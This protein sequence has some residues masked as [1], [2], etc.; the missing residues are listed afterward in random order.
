LDIFQEAASL[1]QKSDTSPNHRQPRMEKNDPPTSS[2]IYQCMDFDEGLL[3]YSETEPV[4]TGDHPLSVQAKLRFNAGQARRKLDDFVGAASYYKKALRI[5]MASD[6]TEATPVSTFTA[7]RVVIPILHNIGQLSYKKGNLKKS[8]VAYKLAL[9]HCRQHHGNE[10]LIVALSLNCLGVFCYHDS[11]NNSSDVIHGFTDAIKIQKR[12]LGPGSKDEA[13]SLNN[14]GRVHVQREEY[15]EAL[16]YYELA[17]VIRRQCLGKE[18]IDYAA[19]ASNAGQSLHQKRV[20]M[21]VPLSFI[22]SFC[23]GAQWNRANSPREKRI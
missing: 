17:L 12:V 2:Y 8:T 18:N 16:Y 4:E 7:H 19:T 6:L 22:E 13:T 14:L 23:C 5:F 20:N 10:D 21:I 1:R 11:V 15:N 3:T 9:E